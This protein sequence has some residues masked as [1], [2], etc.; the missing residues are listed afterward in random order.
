LFRTALEALVPVFGDLILADQDCFGSQEGWEALLHLIPDKAMVETLRKKWSSDP[1]RP[2]E[3]K[4]SD[5]KNEVKKY[6]KKSTQR[7]S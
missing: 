5:I 1:E 7:V 6:D 4:W 3:A 2:S